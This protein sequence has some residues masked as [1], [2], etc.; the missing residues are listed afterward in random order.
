MSAEDWLHSADPRRAAAAWHALLESGSAGD[1]DR[2]ALADWL[3]RSPAHVSEYLWIDAIKENLADPDCFEGISLERLQ[4]D[5]G[6]NVERLASLAPVEAVAP[7]R[8]RFA[9]RRMPFA[10]AA[11]L[12]LACAVG[13]LATSGVLGG[14]AS[15]VTVTGE[16]R[17]VVLPDGSIAELNTK[18]RMQ[19]RFSEAA[20]EVVLTEGEA[21]FRVAKDAG[22]PFRVLS[23]GTVVQAIGTA[24]TVRRDAAE[25]TVTVVE[26][27]VSVSQ[28]HEGG[29]TASAR[30]EI[31]AGERIAVGASRPAQAR[32]VEKV[33][34]A[35]A[36]AWQE[37]RLILDDLSLQQVVA[38][39]NRYNV[40]QIH[41]DGAGLDSRS[42]SGVFDA[43]DPDSFVS[44]LERRGDVRVTRD[45]AGGIL[46]RAA[47]AA[48][49]GRR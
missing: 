35:T 47:P 12:L 23:G 34:V 36:L 2:A 30:V 6:G 48:D 24:F 9:S 29:E 7:V 39:F 22:R 10:I 5:I 25:T 3:R 38:E 43:N 46:V 8:R 19:V 42:I 33:E 49:G 13:W 32:A 31:G 44:F 20:R 41:L 15:Y 14:Q 16:Q 40:R 17:S 21:L 28:S 4:Q 45:P 11:T 27:R 37:R 26:G 1:A 18:S